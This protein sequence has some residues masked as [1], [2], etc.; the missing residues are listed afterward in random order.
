MGNI[1]KMRGMDKDASRLKKLLEF[2]NKK[3]LVM[4][5]IG[6]YSGE[7]TELFIRTGLIK[8]LYCVDAWEGGFDPKDPASFTDMKLVEK[9]FDERIAQ[10]DIDFHKFKMKSDDAV[11]QFEDKFFDLI[12]I[13]A[14]HSYE[15]VKKDIINYF[16]KVKDDGFIA[17][18]DYRGDMPWVQVKPAVDELLGTP[19]RLYGDT[20][21]IFKKIN[22]KMYG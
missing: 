2:T 12:Y 21:W 10:F 15:F 8:S 5:E 13:D 19:E 4:L 3:D 18:H 7:S 6:C 9:T 1:G 22:T 17:G 16:P 11:S 14:N 20:S